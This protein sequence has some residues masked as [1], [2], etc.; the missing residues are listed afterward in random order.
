MRIMK[1]TIFCEFYERI[2]HIGTFSFMAYLLGVVIFLGGAGVWIP[3]VKDLNSGVL[4]LSDNMMTYS[5][6]LMAP[7]AISLLL[8]FLKYKHKVSLVLIVF[9]ATIVVFLFVGYSLLAA[10]SLGLAMLCVV[11]SLIFW[12]LANHD[13]IELDDKR[14]NENIKQNVSKYQSNWG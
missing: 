14:F 9:L 11:L 8:S 6:S 4:A 12:I 10:N 1:D 5:C 2:K 3:V 7:S 13:N